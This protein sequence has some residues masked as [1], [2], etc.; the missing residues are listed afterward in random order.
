MGRRA[1]CQAPSPAIPKPARTH[2]DVGSRTPVQAAGL[3]RNALLSAAVI[4]A[5]L[6]SYSNNSDNELVL[7]DVTI[8]G[9]NP[10]IYS[11][12]S[13]PGFSP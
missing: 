13:I 8:V 7:D 6:L 12:A 11:L 9:L 2:T 5:A 3:W 10:H 4:V 1:R